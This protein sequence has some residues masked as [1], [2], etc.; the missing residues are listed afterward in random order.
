MCCRHCGAKMSEGGKFCEHCGKKVDISLTDLIKEGG[1]W[2]KIRYF[3]DR[4]LNS[5][6]LLDTIFRRKKFIG[7]GCIVFLLCLAFMLIGGSSEQKLINKYYRAFEKNDAEAVL[8]L[9]YEPI[10]EKETN[11]TKLNETR[12]LKDVDKFYGRYGDDITK[13]KISNIEY[14]DN[15][16][17]DSYNNIYFDDDS[18]WIKIQSGCKI[19]VDVM[20]DSGTEYTMNFNCFKIKGKWYLYSVIK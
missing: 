14:F 17:I 13:K 19:T 5:S 18:G 1:I 3:W 11:A 8:S 4:M 6:K 2:K 12:Y 20:N 16:K 10:V 7:I 9:F 15:D